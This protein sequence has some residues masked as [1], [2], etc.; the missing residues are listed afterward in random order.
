MVMLLWSWSLS[1]TWKK[2][3]AVVGP[4]TTSNSQHLLVVFARETTANEHLE[5]STWTGLCPCPSLWAVG[6][7]IPYSRNTGSFWL[8][9]EWDFHFRNLN[10]SELLLS[11]DSEI[12]HFR[13]TSI[14][15][16]KWGRWIISSQH[17]RER[18]HGSKL[19]ALLCTWA[20][21]GSTLILGF[22]FFD[23]VPV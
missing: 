19:R 10:D 9:Q 23:S 5:P 7:G 1:Q 2:K 22:F 14:L 11:I 20:N 12:S 3:R 13:F 15:D 21:L 8:I 6:Y 4:L 17:A 16:E 18:Q